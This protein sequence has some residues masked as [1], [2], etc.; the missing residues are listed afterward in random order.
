METASDLG[1]LSRWDRAGILVSGACAVHCTLLPL[2]IV[3]VPVLG[4][5]RLLD[6]RIEWA[7]IVTTALVGATAHARAYMRDHRHVAPGLIFAAGFSL[8]LCARLFLEEHLAGA[9]AV[10]VGGILA[11]GSHYANVRMCRCCRE[12]SLPDGTRS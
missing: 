2:L 3:A 12:C 10:G 8:V 1:A 4:L 9:Y 7:F 11:A 6:D 5:G